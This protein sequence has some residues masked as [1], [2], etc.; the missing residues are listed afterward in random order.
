M[1]KTIYIGLLLLL[2]FH[3]IPATAD[4]YLGMG[5]AYYLIDD[6]P[7]AQKYIKNY[8]N[9]SPSPQLK[10][11]FELLFAGKKWEATTKFKDFLSSNYRSP[12]GLV[13]IALSMVD[14]I[15]S[16]T[17]ENL[18]RAIRLNPRFSPA[19]LC[20]GVEYMRNRNYPA[21][22]RYLW[23]ALRMSDIGE[24]KIVLGNLYLQL[25][26]PAKVVPL[27]KREAEL[28][29]DDFYFN[30]VLAKAL[31]AM[32]DLDEME[33]YVETALEVD[34]GSKEAM[35]LKAQF[36]LGKRAYQKARFILKK[37]KFPDYHEVYARTFARVLMGLGDRNAGIYLYEIFGQNPWDQ[38]VNK[39]FGLYYMKNPKNF[40]I[41]NWINR[42]IVSGNDMEDL[43]KSF[44]EEYAFPQYEYLPFFE[45]KKIRWLSDS[46]LIAVA[47]LRSGDAEKIYIIDAGNYKILQSFQH[48]GSVQDIFL[49][50]DRERLIISATAVENEKVYLYA[51]DKAG[52]LYRL[53]SLA[54]FALSMASVQVGFNRSGSLA[55]ITDGAISSLAFESPFSIVS[56]YGKTKP[57]YPVYPFPVYQ[58]NF[59][60]R[61]FVQIKDVSI[62][63]RAPIEDLKKYFLVKQAYET[64]SQVGKLIQKGEQMDVTSSEL[65]KIYFSNDLAAFIIYLSDL[66]N[67]FQAMA[68]FSRSGRLIRFDETMFLGPKK[69]AELDVVHFDPEKNE[70]FVLTR[71]KDRDLIRFNYR[72]LLH[73]TL[74]RKLYDHSYNMERETMWVLSERSDKVVYSDT[75]FARIYL[76][77]FSRKK[78][79]SRSDLKRIIDTRAL[80]RIVVATNRGELLKMDAEA[81]FHYL[82][83]SLEGALSDISPDQ[84]RAAAFINGRL[85]FLTYRH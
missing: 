18:Q 25:N 2:T 44:P 81:K 34:P 26:E 10:F 71:D 15:H 55:Y 52:R 4:Q 84:T 17:V 54:R 39:L 43:K 78:M 69:F 1:K 72:S 77:P 24:Y 28:R 75:E 8:F 48:R 35:L 11:G 62:V 53:S 38:A 7:L 57:V 13:G 33:K 60:T 63:E 32:N 82:G 76:K 46:V 68:Y 31:L 80:D 85:Y 74:A 64:N 37:L 36:L 49:S 61:R 19:Y 56:L 51:V 23:Q 58:Y 22:E 30:F 59:S 66:K 16:T 21:A 27:L 29:P 3:L 47:S 12:V 41:Q 42:A 9:Q 73:T 5:I 50:P 14:M 6:I 70:F 65:V 83:P 79:T 45:V 40:N 20:L 67:A